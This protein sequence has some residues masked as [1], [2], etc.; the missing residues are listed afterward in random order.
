MLHHVLPDLVPPIDRQY[1]IVRR[2]TTEIQEA[3]ERGG[4]MASG[5][6]KIIDNAIIGLMHATART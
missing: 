5:A 1:E 2:A 3:I 6:A 4:F